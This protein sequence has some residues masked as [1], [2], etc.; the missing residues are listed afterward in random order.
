[1]KDPLTLQ[2]VGDLPNLVDVLLANYTAVIVEEPA[3]E[4]YRLYGSSPARAVYRRNDDGLKSV[5]RCGQPSAMDDEVR[6]VVDA[7]ENLDALR[8]LKERPQ[9]TGVFLDL[10]GTLCPLVDDP[11]RVQMFPGAK[12]VLETLHDGYGSLVIIS[13]RSVAALKR[14]VG[15]PALT[16]VG[17][18]GLEMSDGGSMRV[19]LPE[20]I[21]QR[22]RDLAEVLESSI[23][24]EGTLLELKELSHAIHYRGALDLEEARQ[25]ILEG[26]RKLNLAGTRITEGKMLVQVRPDYP[27]DKGTAVVMI[28][29]ER[30]LRNVI[31]AGD[32]TTDVDAFR[33]IGEERRKGDLAGTLVGVRHPDAPTDLL[34]EADLVVEGV[35]GMQQL[36]NW[37][38]S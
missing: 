5:S 6:P 14:I 19:L 28:T 1:M 21:A 2:P 31:Y 25:C 16:Y 18:H 8:Y 32:D 11:L 15:M 34:E 24:C 38:A 22:M 33:A 27:L 26:L 30:G 17:N 36:L 20:D 37:M 10:D 35:E 3:S 23:K 12:G 29:R 9:E 4:V 7:L 13:G